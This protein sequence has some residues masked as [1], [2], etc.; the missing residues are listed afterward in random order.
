MQKMTVRA[1]SRRP[2]IHA[3]AHLRARRVCGQSSARA[4][5]GAVSAVRGRR[6]WSRLAAATAAAQGMKGK[7]ATWK[8]LDGGM[9]ESFIGKAKPK[10]PMFGPSGPTRSAPKRRAEEARP[11]SSWVESKDPVRTAARSAQPGAAAHC[12]R[13][14]VRC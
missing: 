5:L 6:R 8:D 14:D 11:V 3:C 12:R 4:P 2:S 1:V 13:P 9:E 10:G 7:E